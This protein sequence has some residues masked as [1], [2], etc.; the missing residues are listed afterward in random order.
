MTEYRIIKG[1]YASSTFVVNNGEQIC[2]L[3][4]DWS[5]DAIDFKFKDYDW[6]TIPLTSPGFASD[7]LKLYKHEMKVAFRDSA[8]YT[9]KEIN[10]YSDNSDKALIRLKYIIQMLD[11]LP[12]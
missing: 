5:G 11:L 1:P 3:Q 6:I 10:G 7:V 8:E 12:F 2:Q 9:I 4:I